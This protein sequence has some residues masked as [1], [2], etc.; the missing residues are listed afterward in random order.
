MN[1]LLAARDLSGIGGVQSYV[2]AVNN[3]LERRG[4]RT[5]LWWKLDPEHD[6]A[7]HYSG[8]RFDLGIFAH[9]A[10]TSMAFGC[11]ER[12]LL[13]SHG[14]IEPE[15]PVPDAD[16][17]AFVS[18]ECRD[19][20]TTH[21]DTGAVVSGWG[22]RHI[23]RQPIDTVFW[24]P[25]ETDRTEP[26]CYRHSY[27]QGLEFLPEV[28]RDLGYSFVH[29]RDKS[30]EEARE[31]IRGAACVI[32]S[33]RG[34]LEA[35]ACGVP[36]VIADDRPYNGGP[37]RSGKSWLTEARTNFSGR[38]GSAPSPDRMGSAISAQMRGSGQRQYVLEHHDVRKIT[39]QLLAA[40]GV[41]VAA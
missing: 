15:R 29:G 28:C 9:G 8:Q 11:C 37:L 17:Y 33:G 6:A 22:E 3:E 30:P 7:K 35:M 13:V 20:W 18:E 39:D 36:V 26:Y 10:E 38:G 4:H 40:A 27:Y 12:T 1:I 31:W 14:L 21:R 16:A 2:D 25:G 19:W 23:V 32:S 41:E 24:C 34:A 5:E